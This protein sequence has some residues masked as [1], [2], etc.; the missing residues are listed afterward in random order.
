MTVQELE[1]RLSHYG[2]M[3]ASIHESDHLSLAYV[4]LGGD[5]KISILPAQYGDQY[6]LIEGTKC[7]GEYVQV[8]EIAKAYIHLTGGDEQADDLLRLSHGL[9]DIASRLRAMASRGWDSL[10]QE[11][12][13]TSLVIALD[14]AT[15]PG[16]KS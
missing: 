4:S 8:D 13:I 9:D 16:A 3:C 5:W 15:W 2:V 11:K 10:N 1:A 14:M 6:H 12:L 7:H